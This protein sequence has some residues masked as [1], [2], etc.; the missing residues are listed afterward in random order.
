[1][2]DTTRTSCE[3]PGSSRNLGLFYQGQRAATAQANGG[4]LKSTQTNSKNKCSEG[5]P[6]RRCIMFSELE[7]ISEMILSLIQTQHLSD[8]NCKE[9]TKTWR[10]TKQQLTNSL[11][12][13]CWM[14]S[15]WEK[16][17]SNT[18][19]RGLQNRLLWRYRKLSKNTVGLAALGSTTP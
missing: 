16:W 4:E 8:L 18:G 12:K 15:L 14:T 3:D 2:G 13:Y 17:H 7:Q 19:K 5:P 1:M 9:L 6:C 10:P 11:N